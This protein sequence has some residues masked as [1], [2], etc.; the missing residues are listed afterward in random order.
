MVNSKIFLAFEQVIDEV[1]IKS[2]DSF[3]FNSFVKDCYENIIK[4]FVS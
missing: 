4:N 3:K 2:E 1:N